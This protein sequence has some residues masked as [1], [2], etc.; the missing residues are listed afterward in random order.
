LTLLDRI[1]TLFLM[2]MVTN[3]DSAINLNSWN[4]FSKTSA[5]KC[6]C[7]EVLISF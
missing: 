4:L 3:R 5:I 7:F 2:L 6:A 1:I